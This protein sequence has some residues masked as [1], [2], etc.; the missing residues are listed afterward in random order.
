MFFLLAQTPYKTQMHI[1]SKYKVSTTS[2]CI[3]SLCNFTSLP[4]GTVYY[5]IR[6]NK[7]KMWIVYLKQVATAVPTVDESF[8]QNRQRCRCSSTAFPSF[9][10]TQM[11]KKSAGQCNEFEIWKTKVFFRQQQLLQ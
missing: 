6:K 4:C 3:F 8:R 9:H 11:F 10:I 7:N 1:M 2:N 5:S